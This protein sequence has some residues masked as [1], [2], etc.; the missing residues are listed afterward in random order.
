VAGDRRQAAARMGVA[1]GAGPA[2]YLSRAEAGM[3]GGGG[4]LSW[5]IMRIIPSIAGGW[6]ARGYPAC[7]IGYLRRQGCWRTG[8]RGGRRRCHLR[9]RQI[10]ADGQ[11]QATRMTNKDSWQSHCWSRRSGSVRPTSVAAGT[12]HFGGGSMACWPKIARGATGWGWMGGGDNNSGLLIG[13]YVQ[14]SIDGKGK[15]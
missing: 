12:R 5:A 7:W 4:A 13:N 10:I 11:Q 8:R 2:G 14:Q 6:N 15:D 9:Q 1:A 3:I